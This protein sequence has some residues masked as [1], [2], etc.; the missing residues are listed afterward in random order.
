MEKNSKRKLSD[1]SFVLGAGIVGMIV[2]ALLVVYEYPGL[3]ARRSAM[4]LKLIVEEAGYNEPVLESS[5]PFAPGWNGCSKDDAIAY[6]VSA[7]TMQ[8]SD[9]DPIRRVDLAVCCGTGLTRFSKGCTV[10]VR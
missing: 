4:D 9:D 10:R 3:M 7:E 1:A 8:Q 2:I 5:H 6:S